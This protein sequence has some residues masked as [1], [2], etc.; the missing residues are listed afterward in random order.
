MLAIV[1]ALGASVGWGWADFLGGTAGRRLPILT[2]S[3][4]SQAVGFAFV[5]GLVVS[6]WD[7]LPDARTVTL[8]LLAGCMGAVGLAALYSALAIGPM[9]VVAPMVSLS[10]VVPV[11]AGLLGGDHPAALQLVGVAA[12]VGGVALAA[13]HRD[14]GGAR[15]TTHAIV[16]AGVAAL[17]LGLLAVFLG[18]AGQTD[19]FWAVLMVRIGSVTLLGAAVILR[20]PSFVME[21]RQRLTLASVGILDSSANLL[22]VL[23]A[24]RGLLSLIAVLAS[25]Y[26]ITTVLLA[27]G[28]LKER[29]SRV[30]ALGVL[31]ALAGVALIAAG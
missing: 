28:V 30:Q 11:A 24:Q 18:R 22:F 25:L 9:G 29:L 16:L 13:R 4:V 2:V 17:S 5:L 27:R 10:V 31:L 20:R 8:G 1:L 21:P 7:G 14:E 26:P 6:G 15:V 3:L 12:A 19:A 23:A